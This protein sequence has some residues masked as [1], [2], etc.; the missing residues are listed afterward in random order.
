MESN[1]DNLVENKIDEI[2]KVVGFVLGDVDMVVTNLI[3]KM[4]EKGHTLEDIQKTIDT[5][6]AAFLYSKKKLL[7]EGKELM[8]D[9]VKEKLANDL[10]IAT[11]IKENKFGLNKLTR[12]LLK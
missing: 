12:S 4:V 10:E 11:L 7:T 3:P 1:I 2:K 5:I 9:I 6:S 8:D